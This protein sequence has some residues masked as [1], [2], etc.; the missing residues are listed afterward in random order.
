MLSTLRRR[1]VGNVLLTG[2]SDAGVAA[3]R[4]IVDRVRNALVSAAATSVV[5]LLVATDQEGG[6]VQVLRGPGFS[7]IPSAL[8]QGGWSASAL[9]D[10]AAR[11]GGELSAA[12]LNVNLAPVADT[13]PSAAA[14]AT[15]APIGRYGRQFGYTTAHVG[16]SAAAFARGMRLAGVATAVKHFPGLGR[17]DRNTDVSSGVTD[18]RTTAEDPYLAPFRQAVAAGAELVMMSTAI[19]AKM[20]PGTPA[21]FSRIVIGDVLRRE[22]GFHGVV[23][24]D[25]LGRARQVTRWSLGDR[26]VKFLRAGGDLVLTVVPSVLPAMYDAVLA[27]AKRDPSFHRQVDASALRVLVA[28]A[29]AGLLR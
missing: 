17:V 26:A 3:T 9:E 6:A 21:A 20:D 29:D 19:Y 8:T 7:G 1:H 12:G 2:R 15:N 18:T 13:V 5:P 4:R 25:D 27:R 22:L 14:A 10:R 23:V 16:D 24:S 11:W 28:K